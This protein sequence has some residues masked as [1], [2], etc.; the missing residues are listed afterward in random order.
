MKLKQLIKVILNSILKILPINNKYVYFYNIWHQYND[1]LKY[2]SEK[3]H[4]L[5]PD[6]KCIWELD[7]NINSNIPS[8][9]KVVQA[10]TP[11]SY[12]FKNRSRIV[13]D[14]S[15]GYIY[16]EFQDS[17]VIKKNMYLSTKNKN[18]INIS[19]WHGTPLKRIFIDIL[20]RKSYDDFFST[21]DIVITGDD[22]T[23]S[24]LERA[25][26]GKIQIRKIG[27]P[28]NDILFINNQSKKN[29]I[30][31]KLKLPFNRKLVLYA[32]TFRSDFGSSTNI[33][34]SGIKQMKCIKFQILF[35][36]L[37]KRFGGDWAF[38]AR[39]HPGVAKNIDLNDLYMKAG[40][41]F[42]NGNFGNDMAEYLFVSDILITDYSSSIF[43]YALT[44][45][46]CFLFCPDITHYEK[47]ERGFY[48][49]IRD[50]PYPF[51]ES[52]EELIYNITWFS[53]EDYADGLKLLLNNIGN[54]DD[55]CT[56]GYVIEIINELLK[57]G[58]NNVKS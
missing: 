32:P 25:T 18:Q 1:N 45:K 31:S 49:N 23:S 3:L 39:L 34:K 52:F 15:V 41:E 22:H 48:M 20:N 11:K 9:V 54:V 29:E 50:L 33:Y 42:Y 24:I 6:I 10:S 55:G 5:F 37:K 53:Q 17:L 44:K 30:K 16:K 26:F 2:I 35:E 7:K 14:N 8:Y 57:K 13:I 4:D 19:I 46:P 51:A 58:T 40:G 28:R 38:V 56:I 43:D 47:I 27:N 36:A 21:S 12:Y